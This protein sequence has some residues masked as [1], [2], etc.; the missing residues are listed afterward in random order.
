MINSDD[1]ANENIKK[2]ITQIG[3]KLLTIHTDY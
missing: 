1:V 2:C 3:H